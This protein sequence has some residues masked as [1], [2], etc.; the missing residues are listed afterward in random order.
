MIEIKNYL[1]KFSTPPNILTSVT[2]VHLSKYRVWRRPKALTSVTPVQPRKLRVWRRHLNRY[3]SIH[4]IDLVVICFC[5]FW[6]KVFWCLSVGGFFKTFSV[7]SF[8]SGG[9]TTCFS[10]LRLL[11]TLM[12][13]DSRLEANS[14]ERSRTLWCLL[15]IPS[16]AVHV[17]V[18]I[19]LE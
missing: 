3:E 1:I 12:N 15:L 18:L 6:T 17:T 16:R 11:F 9:L 13:R 10:W 14:S 8:P 7:L 2:P 5:W 4:L 19:R